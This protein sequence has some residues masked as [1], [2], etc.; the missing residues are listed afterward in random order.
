MAV[1]QRNGR[2]MTYSIEP[3]PVDFDLVLVQGARFAPEYWATVRAE[4]AGRGRRDG[5]IVLAE[6]F[7]S[8]RSERELAEDFVHLIKSLGL[9]SVHVVAVDEGV[10]LVRDV[11]RLEPQ[12]IEKSLLFA[13]GGSKREDMAR[14]ISEF[15]G[16]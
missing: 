12:L 16:L 10:D 15:C 6:W 3:A 9:V 2:V 4:L 8:K 7:D 11:Q 13:N 1:F 14:S 5:R